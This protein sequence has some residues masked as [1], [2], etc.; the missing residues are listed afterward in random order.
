MNELAVITTYYNPVR[1][2]T[3][4][5]NYDV[6]MA[7]MKKAGVT[8]ITVECAFGDEPF[9]LEESPAVIQLRSKTLVWQKERLI[10]IAA[11]YVPDHFKYIAWIDCDVVFMNNSWVKDT[12]KVLKKHQVAQLFK[13]CMRLDKHGDR[14]NDISESFASV[15]S[16]H[17]EYLNYERYDKHGHTGYAW[18]MRREIF[19]KVGLYE[20]A[21]SG[22]ADHFMAHAIY[23]DYNF[24]IQNAL[25]HDE[26]QISHLKEWG[27][28]FYE[29][30]KGSLGCVQGEIEHLWHGDAVDRRYFLRM[31]EI[32]ELGFN[33]WTDI[34]SLPGKPLDWSPGM[35]KLGL[36][37]YFDNY[38]RGR[39]EDG[40]KEPVSHHCG[41]T[42][43]V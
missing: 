9:E 43:V 3:R 18:A 5:K 42:C 12:I 37:K 27:K 7:G 34:V 16:D 4:R 22:S 26:F 17:P 40:A 6:F 31:H 2:Q 33:P 10:N 13:T 15:M 36:V 30:V 1:Y 21:I 38:F 25:K 8:C 14:T 29:I 24:C 35:N 11:S 28:R 32:T 19:D 20:A 39:R 23:D 41:E